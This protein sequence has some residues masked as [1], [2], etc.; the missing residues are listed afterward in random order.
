MNMQPS[1]ST[2]PFDQ[3]Y[4][5]LIDWNVEDLSKSLAHV[6]ARRE[7]FGV[8]PDSPEAMLKSE[9]RANS[10]RNVLGEVREIANLTEYVAKAALAEPEPKF[11]DKVTVQVRNYVQSLAAMYRD[12]PF[13]NFEV[14]D[15][16]LSVVS[17]FSLR[18]NDSTRTTQ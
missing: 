1:N 13:H 11:D 16:I 15:T 17:L 12:N 4:D 14:S 9:G 5:R 10:C 7:A 8:Q 6:V 2:K 18:S 3:K